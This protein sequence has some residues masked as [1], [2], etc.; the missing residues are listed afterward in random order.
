MCKARMQFWQNK[1][2]NWL[3]VTVAEALDRGRQAHN[4]QARYVVN[5]HKCIGENTG[6]KL[7]Y[8]PATGLSSTL[9]PTAD[10]R[11]R[12]KQAKHVFAAS[13]V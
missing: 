3:T 10:M 12:R 6:E 4:T 5:V 13:S 9:S 11:E 7:K 2:R 1:W 8:V